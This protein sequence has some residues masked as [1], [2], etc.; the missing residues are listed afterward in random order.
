LQGEEF[1]Q[2]AR[3]LRDGRDANEVAGIT[4]EERLLLEFAGTVARHAHRVSDDQVQ[5][6]RDAGWTDVQIAEAVYE[7]AL[8][9]LFVRLADS[10]GIRPPPERELDGM[11]P[12]V[13]PPA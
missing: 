3:D 6:L 7:T 1:S 10:F 11:P 9:S 2:A 4:P 13:V 5:G 12:A 8:F